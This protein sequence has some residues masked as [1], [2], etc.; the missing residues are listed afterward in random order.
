MTRISG[1]NQIAIPFALLEEAGLHSGDRVV[2]EAPEQG[3]LRTVD[4]E[5]AFG[6]L[7]GVYPAGYLERL[8]ADDASR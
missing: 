2:I 5:H 4:F 1:K 7:T 3:E 6:A 8:D